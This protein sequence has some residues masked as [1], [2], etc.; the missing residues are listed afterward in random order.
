MFKLLSE[1]ELKALVA[2]GM[3]AVVPLVGNTPEET[4]AHFQKQDGLYASYQRVKPREENE[5]TVIFLPEIYEIEKN[6][7]IPKINIKKR[8]WIYNYVER[9]GGNSVANKT[10]MDTLL[11]YAAD[12]LPNTRLG[13]ALEILHFSILQPNVTIEWLGC[14]KG[15][16]SKYLKSLY[17]EICGSI[18]VDLFSN[19]T[20]FKIIERFYARFSKNN[21]TLTEEL[22]SEGYSIAQNY[23]DVIADNLPNGITS[24]S[25]FM[26]KGNDSWV[27][28]VFQKF[29]D[30]M[31]E[32]LKELRLEYDR[33]PE[34]GSALE[35][36]DKET[37]TDVDRW[38]STGDSIMECTNCDYYKDVD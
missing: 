24:F 9:F 22:S 23:I 13:L 26:Q 11:E 2:N 31:M 7:K 3:A 35:L 33:C 38:D 36:K 6:A 8:L 34:C 30:D 15:T 14:S 29:Y 18:D 10:K 1:R 12:Y 17:D 21:S 20:C 5:N 28:Y 16:T 27:D 32:D 4:A 19:D 37:Q 25:E